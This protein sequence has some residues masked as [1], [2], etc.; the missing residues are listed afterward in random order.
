MQSIFCKMQ[1]LYKVKQKAKEIKKYSIKEAEPLINDIL[2]KFNGAS[3]EWICSELVYNEGFISQLRSREKKTGKPQVSVKFYNQLKN[4]SL[5]NATKPQGNNARNLNDPAYLAGRLESKE[6]VLAEKEARR[7]EAEATA[8]Y[9]KEQLSKAQ[10]EK[11]KLFEALAEAQQTIKEVLKPI[12]EHTGK[13]LANSETI[14]ADLEQVARMVRAD[15]LTTMD[16]LD[17]L[18]GRE[19]G[20]A[21]TEASIVERAFAEEDQDTDM[22]TTKDI[23]DNSGKVKQKGKA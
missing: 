4:F 17:R 19:A 15:D 16:S 11:D 3:E 6:E 8:Q 9:L 7:Q 21:S 20:T 1:T 10:A 18:E 23:E 22:S 12:K 5:Q 14:Q 2:S 13:I